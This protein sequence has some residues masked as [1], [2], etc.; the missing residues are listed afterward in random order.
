[1]S[2][3]SRNPVGISEGHAAEPASGGDAHEASQADY[4]IGPGDVLEILVWKE[5]DLSRTV[6]V[7]MDG[8][9]S[10]PL[11][12]DVQAAGIKPLIL[13]ER[14]TQALSGF[15]DAPAVYVILQE[16]NS[17][18]IYLVGKVNSPG[19]YPLKGNM[20]LLQAIALAGGFAEWA[21]TGDIVII[22]KGPKGQV[23]IK[24][25]YGRAVSGK[26]IEQNILLH[27]DDVIIVP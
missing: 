12:D 10:L 3:P 4:V 5:P 13:K 20:T 23:R 15:V 8:K 26:D 22:R 7:R 21:G 16:Q 24:A 17:K 11:V 1:M 9:I 19:E 27:P 14:I 25:D 2:R 18:R 6:T